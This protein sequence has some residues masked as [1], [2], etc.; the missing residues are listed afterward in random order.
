MKKLLLLA[1]IITSISGTLA[2]ESSVVSLVQSTTVAQASNLT[3]NDIL[4]MTREVIELAGGLNDIIKRG[5]VVV[6]K[7]NVVT[8]LLNW[9]SAPGL[10]PEFVNGC[11]TDRRVVQAVAEIVREII[12]P[13]NPATGRGK[14]MVIEAGA[15]HLRNMG[16][17]KENLIHVDEIIA[18]ESEGSWVRA[19]DASGSMDYVT[20]VTLDNFVYNR[21]SGRNQYLRYYQNDGKYWVNKKMYEADALICIPVLKNHWHAAVTGAIKNIGIGA[22]P[23]SIYGNAA[24]DIGRHN[25]INHNS[26]VLHD[27]IADYFACLPADFVVMDGLQGLQNGPLPSSASVS[28]LAAHQKNLRTIL[29]SRDPLAID[30]V[31][32]NITNWDYTTV[33][34]LTMLG[35]RGTAGPKPNGRIIPLRGD[36]KDIIVLGNKTV[37]DIRGDYAGNMQ[38]GTPGR[39]ISAANQAKPAV[40]I[41]SAAFSGS[42]LNMAL[43][44]S[45]GA[46][47]NVVKIDIYING[48]YHNSFNTNMTNISFDT[49][50][51]A[52]GTHSIEVRAFTKYMFC[53][54]ATATVTR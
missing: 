12:G 26:P 5:D 32:A 46:N 22:T 16:Y 36:P 24:N 40:T 21:A 2:A 10:L 30:I 4:A 49:S 11:S 48:K 51:L 53:S 37:D 31:S 7:P 43:S 8:S 29:A 14:I 44:L 38:A 9:G 1:C 42:N 27:W 34:H 15:V 54:T 17:T 18:L 19:G 13:Y 41:N 52:R 23:P 45:T 50:S 25:M 33:P 47:N 3:Y 39:R 35:A 20:Q 6:L 28:A